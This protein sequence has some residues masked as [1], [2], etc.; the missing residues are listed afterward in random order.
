MH[1]D[2]GLSH[3]LI[4]VHNHPYAVIDWSDACFA[5]IEHE[6]ANLYW[7]NEE[8]VDMAV[9]RYGEQT[10]VVLDRRLVDLGYAANALSDVGLLVRNN[11][12]D[13]DIAKVIERL[14]VL[15]D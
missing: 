10:G 7:T 9:E 13:P 12:S 14:E 11:P 6:L 5:P 8:Y 2:L 3:W 1:A 15:V 4:D